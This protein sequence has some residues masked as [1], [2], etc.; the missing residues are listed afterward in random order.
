PATLRRRKEPP[1]S[2]GM[3]FL[4]ARG[5]ATKRCP[6]DDRVAHPESAGFRRDLLD[7]GVCEVRGASNPPASGSFHPVYRTRRRQPVY[8]RGDGAASRK[9]AHRRKTLLKQLA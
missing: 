8:H 7:C 2:S 4:A 6:P 1:R 3:Y 9:T 5:A